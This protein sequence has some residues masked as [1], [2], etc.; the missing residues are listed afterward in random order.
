MR[1]DLAKHKRFS[2]RG[3]GPAYFRVVCVPVTDISGRTHLRSAERCD[4]LV[5]SGNRPTS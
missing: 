1:R 2:V 5:G 4:M 3:S